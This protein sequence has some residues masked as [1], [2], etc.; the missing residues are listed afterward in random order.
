[1]PTFVVGYCTSNQ[2]SNFYAWLDKE[3]PFSNLE[4]D[5]TYFKA[6]GEVLSLVTWMRVQK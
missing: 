3:Q 1:M 2:D 6:K 4:S 5:I